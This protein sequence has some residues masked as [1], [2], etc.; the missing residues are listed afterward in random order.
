MGLLSCLLV[1]FLQLFPCVVCQ[2]REFVSIDCGGTGNYTDTTTGLTWVSDAD[3]IKHGNVAQVNS[4]NGNRQQYKHHSY[5]PADSKKYCYTLSTTERRRYLIRAT[6]QYG[7]FDDGNPYPIF[8]LYLDST[9]WSDITITDPS[10]VYID[11]MIIRAPST[12]VDVCLCCASTGYPFI[13]TLELRPLNASM[14]ATDYE[15]EFFLK[16]A[17]RVNFG[18]LSKDA[19][20]YPDDPYDR[21]WES[22]LARRQNFLV[23]VA[24]GTER[25][26]TS[27]NINTGA[28]EFPPVKVMQTAVVGTKG[29][30]SYR[31]NL[32]GFP[33]N[34]RAYAYLAEIEDLSVDETRKFTMQK[35]SV[36]GYNN[37]V[38]NIAENANGS[39]TLYEP[40]YMNVSLDFVLSFVLQKTGD[41]TRGPLLNAIEIS[42]FVQIIPKTDKRD[43]NVLET[44]R[45][46][47]TRSYWTH[48]DGDPCVPAHWEWVNCSASLP[49]RITKITLS[50][51]DL[52]GEIPSEINNMDGLT[53]LWLDGNSLTGRIP[54]MSNLIDLTVVHLENNRLT[55]QLP[56]YLGDL[57]NLQEL[58]VQNNSFSGK[59]PPALLSGKLVF[60]YDENPELIQTEYHKSNIK[61]ILGTSI[62]A[63]LIF[64]LITVSLLLL[65]Y[66]RRKATQRKCNEKSECS[67]HLPLLCGL[68]IIHHIFTLVFY[69]FLCYSDNSMLIM[70]KPST[71]Y[72]LIR[73][74]SV[75]ID[76]GLDVVHIK[77]AEIEAATQDFSTKIG[78]GSFGNVYYGKLKDGK[79]VAV[80]IL[81]DASYHGTK[82]FENEV[83]SFASILMGVGI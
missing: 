82:Q 45:T 7:I 60:K 32:Y 21:L 75:Y 31:L 55:G 34:A 25:I 1:L 30:L 35:P 33:G 13:S 37:I 17:A 83:V 57:P 26:S 15:D 69:H 46:M 68:E 12:S 79:E 40:S 43:S 42:K 19:I 18:A 65:Q 9:K 77:F 63:F 72:S 66:L 38:V 50:G 39:Y 29:S 4:S 53:E 64:V 76:D 47:T 81:A 41:S 59:I 73:G 48:E 14:Y 6:F 67:Q 20:R 3:F 51:K 58:Y 54:D 10:R 62:G 61:F 27:M 2:V 36:P 22:D 80:K 16:V 8:Q 78:K 52:K 28:R 56:Y 49:S 11:E 24:P 70:S 71:S 23:G 74:G 44:F 5:F